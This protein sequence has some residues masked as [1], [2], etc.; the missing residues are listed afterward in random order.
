[1]TDTWQ[2]LTTLAKCD[3]CGHQWRPR[4]RVRPL[5]GGEEWLFRCER[6]GRRYDM[7]RITRRGVEWR[8]EIARLRAE[9]RADDER[10]A[11][12]DDL[13]AEVREREARQRE[14][15]ARIEEL[16]AQLKSEVTGRVPDDAMTVG[17]QHG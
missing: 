11:L 12:G 17:V 8:A 13:A 4:V 14:V 9:L 16:T 10:P 1:M 7:A 5:A 3:A 15:E 2:Q 6:C